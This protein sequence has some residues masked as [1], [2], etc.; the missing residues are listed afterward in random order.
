MTNVVI[1]HYA[2]VCLNTRYKHGAADWLTSSNHPHPHH[3][4]SPVGFDGWGEVWPCFCYCKR[5]RLDWVGSKVLDLRPQTLWG[6]IGIGTWHCPWLGHAGTPSPLSLTFLTGH[7]WCFSDYSL[8]VRVL[9]PTTD[10]YWILLHYR[11]QLLMM[12]QGAAH[13]CPSLP[14]DSHHHPLLPISNNASSML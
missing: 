11:H 6:R 7:N 14:S 2:A 3:S 5:L 8:C 12:N 10:K 1:D 4:L 13:Y 9:I